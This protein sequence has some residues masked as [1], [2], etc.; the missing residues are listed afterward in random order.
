MDVEQFAKLGEHRDTQ[1]LERYV[2]DVP[3][4]IGEYLDKYWGDWRNGNSEGDYCLYP[5]P[6]GPPLMIGPGSRERGVLVIDGER[7]YSAAWL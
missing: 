3:G 7:Y 1:R 4:E 6:L 5:S 2:T